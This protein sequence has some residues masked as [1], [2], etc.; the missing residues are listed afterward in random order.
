[1]VRTQP[2][3]VADGPRAAKAALR[4]DLLAAR[5]RLDAADAAEAGARLA[6]HLL[7]DEQVRLAA[8][9]TAYVSVGTEPATAPLL[10]ALREAGAR[11]LLPVLLPDGDLDWA[12]YDGPASLT[13]ATRSLLEPTGARLGPEAVGG[14]DVVLLPGLAVSPLGARLGRGGG[15]YDRAL[16][17]VSPDA[18]TCV[19]LH[20]GEAGLDVPVEPH[21]RAVGAVVTPSGGLVRLARG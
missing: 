6:G 20:D 11:V 14:A 2:S 8:T 10:E 12:A 4:R 21:D 18:L 9:V 17:R 7:A 3:R 13:P 5:R 1:M 15:S 16:A 19:L